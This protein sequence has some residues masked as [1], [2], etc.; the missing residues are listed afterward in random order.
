MVGL[1]S[2]IHLHFTNH[3]PGLIIL[4]HGRSGLGKTSTAELI[5]ARTKRALYPISCNGTSLP[6][7]EMER[8]LESHLD[9]AQEWNC[10]VLI[11]DVDC[12]LEAVSAPVISS[13]SSFCHALDKYRGIMILTSKHPN[14][15]SH[16]ILSRIQVSLHFP[17]LGEDSTIRV[18]QKNIDRVRSKGL[19][20]LDNEAE[21]AILAFAKA[22][23]TRGRRWNGRQIRNCFQN[24]ISLAEYDF[25]KQHPDGEKG[26]NGKGTTLDRPSLTPKIL[27]TAAIATRERYSCS[28]SGVI[29]PG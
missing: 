28:I 7:N 23:Y 12:F 5:A 10:I 6:A 1:G 3:I 20:N 21:K 19:V 14:F 17:I 15:T 24:A 11:D 29:V 26:A 2:I 25:L 4:L 8:V 22:E 16:E 27:E 9:R 13:I 18:W